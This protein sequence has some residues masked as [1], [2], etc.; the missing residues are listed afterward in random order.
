MGWAR[1]GSAWY[2]LAGSAEEGDTEVLVVTGSVPHADF[3]GRALDSEALIKFQ[4]TLCTAALREQPLRK[5]S[6]GHE[7]SRPAPSPAPSC[8]QRLPAPACAKQRTFPQATL[9]PGALSSSSSSSRGPGR[10]L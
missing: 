4:E 7:L 6:P 3:L 8:L 2:S 1:Q 10:W 9:C 5:H